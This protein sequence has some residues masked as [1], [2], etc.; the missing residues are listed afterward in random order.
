MIPARSLVIS[1][2]INAEEIKTGKVIIFNDQNNKR[3]TAHRTVETKEGG[4]TTRG[5]ANEYQDRYVVQPMDIIGAVIGVFPLG[6]FVAISLQ[7]VFLVLALIFGMLLKQFLL[8]IK[9]GVFR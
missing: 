5:D 6:N 2:K 1:K 3:V 4:Y 7:V 9:Y 8:F